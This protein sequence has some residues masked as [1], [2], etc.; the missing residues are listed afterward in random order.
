MARR[1]RTGTQ[2]CKEKWSDSGILKGP[3]FAQ[4][5]QKGP[6]ARR[7]G[8]RGARRTGA[9]R[10][11]A[12]GARQRR[13]WSFFSSLKGV[14]HAGGGDGQRW[15]RGVLR[16]GARPGGGGGGGRRAGGPPGGG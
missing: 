16:R 1:R 2:P 9:V 3:V 15:D 6:D 12:A 11:S 4:A 10:R 5:A 8:V 14:A 7:Q 13:R